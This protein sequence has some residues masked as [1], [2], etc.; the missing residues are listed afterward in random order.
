MSN[1]AIRAEGLGKHYTT[2]GPTRGYRTLRESIVDVAAGRWW[3]RRRDHQPGMWALR[4]ISFEVRPGDVLGIIGRNGAGKSTLLKV[5]S[6]ITEPSAGFAEVHG[7]VGSL[8][9]VGTGF[10][11]ELSGR[12]NIFLSGAILGMKSREIE[13]KFD[14]IVAFAEVERFVDTALKHYSSGM[15]LRLA[16]AVAAHLEP[17]ILMVDEVLAVGDLAFQRKCL[18][19]MQDVGES[20]QT[21][22]FVSHDL[23]AISRLA[24]RTMVL[25]GGEVAFYGDTS[26]AIQFYAAQQQPTGRALAARADRSGDGVIRLESLHFEDARGGQV[27]AV[28]SG[29]ALSLVIGYRS[30]LPRL[31]FEDLALDVRL[32]D[33][34]GHPI[35]TVSTR[36]GRFHSDPALPGTGALCCRIPALPLATETYSVDLWLAYRGGVTDVVT[37]AGEIRVVSAGFFPSGDEPVKRKHGA[38][39]I[40]HEWLAAPLPGA[41]ESLAGR[42]AGGAR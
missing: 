38:A 8:L 23:T 4:D 1:V 31:S 12:E 18:G 19:K 9:E 10:H 29:E 42:G 40:T 33:V 28:G 41:A 30:E 36:F 2:V 11:P 3:R 14:Q 37:R 20:G 21:V 22:L 39:L 24:P 27:D 32:T 16:F 25:S 5:L 17:S 6:R 7:R 26:E 35:A 13:R 15:Y 34:L